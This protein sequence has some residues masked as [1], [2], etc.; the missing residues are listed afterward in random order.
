MLTVAQQKFIDVEF[1]EHLEE[2]LPQEPEEVRDGAPGVRG[3]AGA[4]DD[5][6]EG[7]R[8][9]NPEHEDNYQER[10]QISQELK[11]RK[12]PSRRAQ[13]LAGQWNSGRSVVGSNPKRC[14]TTQ[15]LEWASN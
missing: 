14:T 12:R 3:V 6:G 13:G 15:P 4:E 8:V 2:S 7:D 1:S 5:G 11:G 9:H 10:H